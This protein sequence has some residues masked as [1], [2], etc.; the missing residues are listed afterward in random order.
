MF[1]LR[2]SRPPPAQLAL[3]PTRKNVG[4]FRSD[5]RWIKR[6]S[7]F[8][9]LR[10]MCDCAPGKVASFPALLAHRHKTLG[11]ELL[12]I[13]LSLRLF[14]LGAVFKAATLL[15]AF[16]LPN[17]TAFDGHALSV[18]KR[19]ESKLSLS[20]YVAMGAVVAANARPEMAEAIVFK[21]GIENEA[22]MRALVASNRERTCWSPA[23]LQRVG[24]RS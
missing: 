6:Y 8:A 2:F 24:R 13:P 22:L 9:T 12:R 17:P 10:V 21:E 20:D 11:N 23:A 1:S 16:F 4:F 18:R 15:V 19:C 14:L 5:L 3:K 7:N